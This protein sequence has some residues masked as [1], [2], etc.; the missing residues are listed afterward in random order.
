MNM[1]GMGG[2]FNYNVPQP[3]FKQ[4]AVGSGIDNGEFNTIVASCTKAFAGKMNPLP[5]TSAGLIKQAIGGEWF[6]FISP[7]GSK[8]FDFCLTSVSGGDFMSFALDNTCFQVCR[9]K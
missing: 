1:Y 6:V 8:D 5:S 4:F 3:V 2:G 7:V 9:L